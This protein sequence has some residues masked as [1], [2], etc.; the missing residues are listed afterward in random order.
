MH[1]FIDIIDISDKVWYNYRVI[2]FHSGVPENAFRA[3]NRI[4]EGYID[5]EQNQ[6]DL[7]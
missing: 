2:V 3:K 6:S 5:Y 7:F 4:L 1:S